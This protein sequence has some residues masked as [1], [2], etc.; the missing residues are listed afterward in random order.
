[1]NI[2]KNT[3]NDIKRVLSGLTSIV[4]GISGISNKMADR[5]GR[6][7]EYDKEMQRTFLF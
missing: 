5:H 7:I 4:S 2:E 3:E 6:L 1:L